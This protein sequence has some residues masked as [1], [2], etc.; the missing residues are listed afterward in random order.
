MIILKLISRTILV[1]IFASLLSIDIG[2][3][4]TA[5]DYV[6][7][8]RAKF[9]RGDYQGSIQDFNKAIELNP[10]DATFYAGRGFPKGILKDYPGA[11]QDFNKAIG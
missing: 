7:K 9:E 10:N 1:V 2:L 11:I 3:A 6:A 8:G 5:Q 4:Q